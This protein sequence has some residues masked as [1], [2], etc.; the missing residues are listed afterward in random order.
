M[1]D[2]FEYCRRI[3]QKFGKGY[4]FATR[5]FPQHIRLGTYALYAWTRIPDDIVDI[6]RNEEKLA[7][8]ISDWRASEKVGV[9]ARPEMNAMLMTRHKFNIPHKYNDAFLSSMLMD[10]KK[11]SYADMSELQ[12]Y[13]YG[14]ATSVGLMMMHIFGDFRDEAV[15]YATALA[16]AMQLTNFLR[17]IGEDY[18]TKDRIYL[19]LDEMN[20]YGIGE[21]NIKT[22]NIPKEFIIFK[23]NQARQLFSKAKLGIHLLPPVARY[24]ILLAGNLYEA[25][26]D[27]IEKQD[28]D[29][30]TKRAKTNAWQKIL[31]SIKTYAWYLKNM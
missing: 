30:F 1:I 24:P 11:R 6:E 17:D 3:H 25:I 10:F 4:Y 16:E 5:F 29:V 21:D 31:I 19:P 8:W 14:S 15:P 23:I 12:G 28:Y 9:S 13:M 27:Q 26:L 2:D 22:Q 7:E 20:N 18:E